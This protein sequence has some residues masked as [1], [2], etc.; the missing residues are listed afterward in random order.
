[1]LHL[2]VVNKDR[3]ALYII[4]KE[5]IINIKIKTKEIS[6]PI[7]DSGINIKKFLKLK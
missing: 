4:Y 7:L 1:M 5:D 6:L 2:T 3:K